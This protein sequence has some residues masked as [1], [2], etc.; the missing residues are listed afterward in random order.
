MRKLQLNKVFSPQWT[1]TLKILMGNDPLGTYRVHILAGGTQLEIS[2]PVTFGATAEVKRQLKAHPS[3][4]ILH[5]NSQGGR[6]AEAR[7]LAKLIERQGLVTYTAS[8]CGSASVLPFAAGSERLIGKHAVMGFHQYA[9][10]GMNQDDFAHEYDRDRAF[11]VR[12]GVASNFI[13]KIFDAAHD[14]LWM[15]THTELFAAN[16][17]T[18]YPM[19]GEVADSGIMPVK[20]DA[21]ER[22]VLALPLYQAL[23]AA[24]PKAYQTIVTAIRSALEQG[25]GMDEMRAVTLPIIQKIQFERLPKCSDAAIVQFAKVLVEQMA[26]L[27]KEDPL[28]CYAFAYGTELPKDAAGK[29][30]DPV[31]YF[32]E[33]IVRRQISMDA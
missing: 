4:K 17:V 15:P 28:L 18:R 32:S 8:G 21:V 19:E 20:W 31:V 22:E 29:P 33:E 27:E 2:G 16:F 3:V 5:L 9:F 23:A 24:E 6:I 14:S 11:F 13:D 10:P 7:K 30:K 12:R 25:Q 1:E 26:I